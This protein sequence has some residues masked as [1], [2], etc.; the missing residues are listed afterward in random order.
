MNLLIRFTDTLV[1]ITLVIIIGNIDSGNLSKL[2]SDNETN[3]VLASNMFS[4]LDNTN[5]AKLTN[6]TKNGAQ[7]QMNEVRALK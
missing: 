1:W 7:V 5:T 3:A 2:K 4:S 6:A